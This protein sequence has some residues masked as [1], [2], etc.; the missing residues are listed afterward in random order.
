MVGIEPIDLGREYQE[1]C[2]AIPAIYN[3]S[4]S[5]IKKERLTLPLFSC[6]NMILIWLSFL[7]GIYFM[8]GYNQ[9][10]FPL[11]R[12]VSPPYEPFIF[13][14]VSAYP[15]CSDHRFEIWRLFSMQF[16]HGGVSHILGNTLSG[17][18][19]GGVLEALTG[20]G[21]T[22]VVFESS[23]MLGAISH[24]C[25][26]PYHGL[27]GCSHGVYGWLG[28]LMCYSVH[29]AVSATTSPLPR[30]I[31]YGILALMLI[32]TTFHNIQGKHP[33]VQCTPA[34]CFPISILIGYF[35][36]YDANLAYESH[37]GGYASGFLLTS[38]MLATSAYDTN[39]ENHYTSEFPTHRSRLSPSI[40]Y[41]VISALILMGLLVTVVVRFSASVVTLHS[42][43][44]ESCC[45]DYFVILYQQANISQT[46]I[47]ENYYCS[48]KNRL[49]LK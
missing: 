16:V 35:N 47:N 30:K 46:Y 15:V 40:N 5:N 26:K 14:T 24:S 23:I 19:I 33:R 27:I 25:F 49:L 12:I 8:H 20:F 4:V 10:D 2:T 41:S 13:K 45:Q 21:F 22:A 18:I 43:R 29:K 6:A 7:W 28:A 39:R 17:V 11:H 48:S 1:E 3:V 9:S 31:C 44:Y 38:C 32:L 37:A 34:Y 36:S 42:Q